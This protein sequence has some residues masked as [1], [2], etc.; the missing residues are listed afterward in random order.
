MALTSSQRGSVFIYI[1]IGVFLFAALT[2]A[3][4]NSIRGNSSVSGDRS[5]LSATEIIDTGNKLAEAVTRLRL[6][7]V[8]KNSIS[9]QNDIDTN[10][11]NPNCSIDSCKVFANGGGGLTWQLPPPNVTLAPWFYTADFAL[12]NIGTVNGG[13][14]IAFL[15][16]ISL[17]ICTKINTAL[18]IPSPVPSIAGT[19]APDYF[20]GTYGST[21]IGHPALSGKTAGCV[22]LGT[23]TG[24]ALGGATIINGYH[25]YQ[26]LVAN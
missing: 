12:E 17:E 18:G 2:Y 11:T 25:F 6:H 4:A 10:Y 13:D 19:Y 23:I 26:V 3:I 22:Q 21:T 20:F 16:N 5:S 9:L 8:R 1:L 7:D 15:P 14:L 24:T